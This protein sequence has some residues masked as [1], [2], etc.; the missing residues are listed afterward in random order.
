MKNDMKPYQQYIR[1]LCQ[2]PEFIKS[3]AH[4][5]GAIL[6]SGPELVCNISNA[7]LATAIAN[8]EEELSKRLDVDE[9]S[10]EKN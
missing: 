9:D 3:I 1:A 10:L 2:N 8:L 4:R 7:Q 6:S 5:Y